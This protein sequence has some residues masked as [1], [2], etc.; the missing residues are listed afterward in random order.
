VNPAT[1]VR[2]RVQRARAQAPGLRVRF[3][4][5]PLHRTVPLL[6]RMRLRTLDVRDASRILAELEDVNAR[7]AAADEEYRALAPQFDPGS[8][9]AHEG[10]LLYALVRARCPE[11]IVETGTASGISTTYLLAALAR[12]EHGRLYSIDLPFTADGAGWRGVVP[13]TTIDR[14]DVSP[15]PA[16]KEPGWVVPA[17]LRA[18]W[19]LRL[20]DARQLLLELLDEVGEIGI[21]FHD[22]LHTREHM[23]FELE[24][25]WPYL[26]DGG[27]L[28]V[29][30]V[31]QRKHDALPAF[32]RSVDRPFATFGNVGIIV[33]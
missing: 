19:D 5:A 3:L 11:V 14:Y 21:F 29:D 23:L 20:G 4:L 27:L 30:D 17:D 32:A 12:N 15:I 10:A 1:R 24:T 28:L 25:A 8:L 6:L 26:A 22:S 9:F 18:R 7:V 16:G 33:K 31:F 2:R 13:G